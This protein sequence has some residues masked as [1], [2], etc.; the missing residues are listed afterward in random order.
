MLWT[1]FSF[2]W[3]LLSEIPL[4]AKIKATFTSQETERE[5]SHIQS[6]WMLGPG[7]RQ[8]VGE[9]WPRKSASEGPEISIQVQE[10]LEI[11]DSDANEH[12]SRLTWADSVLC[13]AHVAW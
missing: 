12:Q 4:V 5:N 13:H 2:A 8:K 3:V 7:R 1:F 10:A 11:S 6:T 9:R